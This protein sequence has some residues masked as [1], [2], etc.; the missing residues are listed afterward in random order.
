VRQRP[1]VVRQVPAHR[2]SEVARLGVQPLQPLA[3]AGAQRP[4]RL[5]GQGLVIAGVAAPD[6]GGVGPGDFQ[7][8]EYP[9]PAPGGDERAGVEEDS[10]VRS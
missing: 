2:G 9:S 3:L 8:R 7:P 1:G 5:L 10:P 6:L 4:I